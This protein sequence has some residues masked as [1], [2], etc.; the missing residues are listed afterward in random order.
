MEMEMETETRVGLRKGRENEDGLKERKE[1]MTTGCWVLG[2]GWERA[3][4]EGEKPSK[5]ARQ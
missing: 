1:R 2:A 5:H 3:R 4:G